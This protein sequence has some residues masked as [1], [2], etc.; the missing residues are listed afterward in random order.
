MLH[1]VLHRVCTSLHSQQCRR[2][3]FSPHPL[4]H[5]LLVDFLM[6]A[7][8][9]GISGYLLIEIFLII[10]SVDHLFMWVLANCISS[11]EKCL[12]RSST[13][14][15]IGL[16]VFLILCIFWKSIPYQLLCLQ[17]FSSM[18][19]VAF[20]FCLCFLCCTKDFKI[21]KVLL[22]YFCFYFHYSG[23]WNQKRY[24]CNLY[25]T[26]LPM[27]ASKSFIASDLNLGLESTFLVQ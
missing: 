8:L 3:F 22:V 14:Y 18:I 15:L 27:F 19:W 21:N 20:S 23:R 4:Q 16:L 10:S 24:C 9:P 13:H 7:I 6:M 11:L 1:I 26:L 2:V 25:K 17:I 5:L 12:F